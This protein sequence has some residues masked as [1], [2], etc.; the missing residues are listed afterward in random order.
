VIQTAIPSI[1]QNDAGLPRFRVPT[2]GD[3]PQ[4]A[5]A[6]RIEAE[7][8][9][10]AECRAFLDAQMESGD[11]LLDVNPGF[12]FV[13]LSAATA[14]NGLP[15]VLV[16]GVSHARLQQLQDAA[17][18][19][20][21]W[22]DAVDASDRETLLAALDGR[23]EPEGRVFVHAVS[24]NVPWVCRTLAPFVENGR[25][26]A[27]C[28]SDAFSS[29]RWV[30]ADH[31]LAASAFAPCAL[32]ERGGAAEL[33]PITGPPS[34]PV[35]A[36]PA[37]L[38]GGGRS[39]TTIDTLSAPAPPAPPAAET[40]AEKATPLRASSAWNAVRDGF[41]FIAPYAR[42]GYGIAAAQLLRALQLRGVPVA[43]FPYGAVDRS[44]IENPRL[45]HA[46]AAQDTFPADA[47]SVRMAQQFDLALHAGRGSRI[48]YTVFEL[49]RFTA[50]ELHHIRQQDA[51]L[52]CTEWARQVC[53]DN[54]VTD[55][56][57]AVVPHGVDRDIFHERVTPGA[58]S[59]DT[60]FLQVGKL[61]A[62]KAQVEL[63]RAFEA[64]FTPGDD[65][66]L[67][68]ACAN[69]FVS[70]TEMDARLAPFRRSPMAA[71]ITLVT[72]PLPALAD[73]AALMA[74]A[75]CGVFP[76]RAEGWNLE[77]L[78]MLSMGKPVIATSVTGH[79]EYLNGDNAR[80]IRVDRLEAAVPGMP[81]QWSAWG[82]AQH[83]QL[84][85]HLRDVHN[86]R[87][88]GTLGRND[89]GIRTAQRYSW[90]AAA[91][92]MLR[93]LIAFTA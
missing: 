12:G 13:A 39:D 85:A 29:E 45:A 79:T 43:L 88:S 75:H 6:A 62:R 56:P 66:R 84:V 1:Q 25:L 5:D 61:E 38:T 10:E 47:P 67:V 60:V 87:V 72:S 23:L 15:T 42:T 50:R 57:I 17:A 16:A 20:G 44:L 51:L 89:A 80:L 31:A 14:P 63:L 19:A 76:S 90:D 53:F 41:S 3:D 54:G 55:R 59:T 24:A 77:A 11:V 71:R 37:S 9:V 91:D 4:F 83:D 74:T 69:P 81:G 48:A 58:E 28:V 35:I 70:R 73:I 33:L 18:D 46:I 93:A 36:I 86:R 65:V 78:E 52:V 40:V 64:A 27:V 21:G 8:G 32:V 7:G 68:L 2:D 26:L 92:A 22:I 34:A 49:D 30:D 82:A